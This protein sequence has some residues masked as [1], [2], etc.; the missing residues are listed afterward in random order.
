MEYTVKALADLAG[1]TPRT[2]RWY[3]KQGLLPPARITESG[4]RLYGPEQVDRLWQILFYRALDLPLS[5]IRA[6]LE[7]PTGSR[8]ETLRAHLVALH[9]KRRQ[10]DSLISLVE[11]TI[12]AQQGGRKMSD[13][14]KFAA[15]KMQE[16]QENE[17]RFGREAR[18]KY[19]DEAVDAANAALLSLSEEEYNDLAK[20]EAAIQFRLTNAVRHGIESDSEEALRIA[21]M[22]RRWCQSTWGTY[23]PA[24]HAG[25]AELYVTDDRFT[26][27]YDRQLPGCA[28]FLREAILAYTENLEA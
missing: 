26:A 9:E 19:G 6:L 12:L 21:A 2:L 8:E 3:D 24:M 25:V 7:N 14:E 4:Y 15:F 1:V 10:L 13:T 11:N 5:E 23:S 22:H 20:L 28:A 27:Y 16:V 17:A 18:E